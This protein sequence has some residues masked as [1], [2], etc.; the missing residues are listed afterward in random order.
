MHIQ[1]TF[2]LFNLLLEVLTTSVHIKGDVVSIRHPRFFCLTGLF[3]I[4]LRHKYFRQAAPPFSVRSE[5]LFV[6]MHKP[7][8]ILQAKL[9]KH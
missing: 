6:S 5:C 1:L 9:L 3:H 8:M 2:H 4:I 7:P